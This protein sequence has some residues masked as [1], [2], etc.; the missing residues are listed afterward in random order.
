MT[1]IRR[2]AIVN[3]GEP[4]MRVLAAVAEL[5]ASGEHPP[6]TTIAVHTDPDARAW[7]VSEADEAISLGSATYVDPA[8]GHRTSRYLDE[9]YVVRRLSEAGADAVWVG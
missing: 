2:L 8:T 9:E 1:Q 4:A 5:N 7:Y 6:I 3:R